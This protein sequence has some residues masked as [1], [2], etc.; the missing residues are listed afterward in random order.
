[1][2]T[3]SK[4][5]YW[6]E[7]RNRDR[8]KLWEFFAELLQGIELVTRILSKDDIDNDVKY[9]IQQI[10]MDYVL[11]EDLILEKEIY[12]I[13][14]NIKVDSREKENMLNFVSFF[15]EV[16][17]SIFQYSDNCFGKDDS[18]AHRDI[19]D[20]IRRMQGNISSKK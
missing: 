1:M 13:I 16:C 6:C 4:F 9:L 5:R 7:L 11:D 2:H 3:Y 8:E 12:S 20:A 10:F 14:S 18:N 19:D 17:F 15:R